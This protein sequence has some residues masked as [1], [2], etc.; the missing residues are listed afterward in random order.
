MTTR[1]RPGLGSFRG[2]S[3]CPL[4]R[5]QVPSLPLLTVASHPGRSRTSV[6]T[7]PDACCVYITKR[8]QKQREQ[9]HLT[10][11]G[12][13]GGR[14][15]VCCLRC[16]TVRAEREATLRFFQGS[17]ELMERSTVVSGVLKPCFIFTTT[18]W[19]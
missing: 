6:F 13:R 17:S 11:A 18:Q 10:E 15:A 4:R 16:T 19:Q 2:G 14:G 1:R 9:R 12:S 5:K 7:R 3:A 8:Q